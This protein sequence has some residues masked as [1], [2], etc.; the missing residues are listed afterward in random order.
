L[1]DDVHV[2]AQNPIV[3]QGQIDIYKIL[4]SDYWAQVK[5]DKSAY[6]PLTILLHAGICHVAGA[7]PFV[8]HLVSIVL[9]ATCAVLVL[10]FLR[11]LFVDKRQA[12]ITALFFAIHPTN[13][14]A[15][16]IV[17]NRSEIVQACACLG[18]LIIAERFVFWVSARSRVQSLYKSILFILGMMFVQALGVFSKENAAVAPLL[19]ASYLA[20][21]LAQQ[22]MTSVHLV[23]AI[24]AVAFPAMVVLLY[25]LIRLQILGS[26]VRYEAFSFLDNP[27]ASQDI[28][29]RLCTVIAVL[30]R[31]IMLFFLPVGISGDYS[32]AQIPPIHSF[33]DPGFLTGSLLLCVLVGLAFLCLKTRPLVSFGILWFL[34]SIFPVSNI[35]FPIGTIMAL[36]LCYL[37]NIGLM[38]ASSEGVMAIWHRMTPLL[39][40]VA[41]AVLAGYALFFALATF[42]YAHKLRTNCD[43]FEE[44]VR[45]SPRS[46][47]ALY[48]YGVCALDRND[49]GRAIMAFDQSLRMYPDYTDAVI[50]L[51]QALE[52]AGRLEDAIAHLRSFIT[53]H[54]DD[55]NAKLSLGK[56]LA[57]N[58]RFSEARVV[59]QEILDAHPERA[60]AREYLR[61]LDEM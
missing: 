10:F 36:R 19:V 41:S 5:E 58:G 21:I 12:F 51:A 53:Q 45:R 35:P 8:H 52:T 28:S 3:C 40:R 11:R 50:Q 30:G 17:S 33:L 15:V 18:V 6:R 24:L 26:L 39:K 14:E 61:R 29:V 49:L 37:P 2:V 59:F 44:T 54:P 34:V 1:F 16:I 7:K 56:I 47:K 25:I 31:Y 20:V 27:I 13:S 9:H 38:I 55:T 60:D 48:G 57:R 23:R 42:G 32:F 46:A 22:K 4:R 43:F